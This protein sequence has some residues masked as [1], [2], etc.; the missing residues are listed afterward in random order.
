MVH[1][2]F[3][4]VK[5][6]AELVYFTGCIPNNPSLTVNDLIDIRQLEGLF[7]SHVLLAQICGRAS[8]E[9]SNYCILA[10]TYIMRMWQVEESFS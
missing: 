2:I 4:K 8:P 3:C 6:V 7:R 10:Y 5:N 9:F 1:S